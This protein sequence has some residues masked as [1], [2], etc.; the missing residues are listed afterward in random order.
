MIELKDIRRDTKRYELA[1]EQKQKL[2]SQH[3][4]NLDYLDQ[5]AASYGFNAPLEVHNAIVAEQEAVT[6][7][8]RELA[9]MGISPQTQPSWQALIIDPDSDW[10]NII[11]N[12]VARLGGK[13]I[14]GHTVPLTE[15]AQAVA[16]CA[17]AII[18]VTPQTQHDPMIREWL[19]TVVKLGH[20]LP[21]ILLASWEDRDTPIIL[22]Q[23]LR[24][25]NINLTPTTIFKETFDMVWFARVLHHLLI[26]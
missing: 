13:A 9:M 6:R 17:V 23:A 11:A 14:E 4:R 3:R 25:H 24:K 18:G 20:K 22:R 21:L 7:L 5:Q 2:L 1:I 15:Q 26:T 8:E 16:D 10:R 19:K 12:H